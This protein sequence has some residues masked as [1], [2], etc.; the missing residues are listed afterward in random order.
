MNVPYALTLLITLLLAAAW[1]AARAKKRGMKTAPVFTGVLF[2]A[3]LACILAKLLYVLLLSSKV[4]PRYGWASLIR[5]DAA[6]FSVI[7]GAL[8]MVLGMVLA[9]KVYH[10]QTARMLSLFAPAGALML[11]G[12]R[13]AEFFLGMQGAGAYVENEAFARLPFAI[14]NEWGEWFWAIFLLEALAALAV[15]AVFALRKKEDGIAS[16]RFERTVYYLCVPQIICESL[17]AL[18]MRWGFVRIEQVLCG[19]IIEGLLIYGCLQA[20]ANSGFWKR[21]WPPIAA[22]GCVGVIVGCEFGLDKTPLP[23]L[24]WYCVMLAALV[25]YGVLEHVVTARRW[26]EKLSNA[27]S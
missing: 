14:S 4:W 19:V 23:D 10:V 22:L 5:L 21:F 15:A 26:R 8:G 25:G 18:G 27:E 7:G 9:A 16:L 6:E 2:G 13:I 3:A 24:F 17:R 11:A 20:N 1:L 12:V